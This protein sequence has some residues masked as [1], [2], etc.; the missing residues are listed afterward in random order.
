MRKVFKASRREAF[1]STVESPAPLLLAF[2]VLVLGR[3][4]K[5]A[6][7]FAHVDRRVVVLENF[8]PDDVLDHIFHGN[9]ARHGAKLVDCDGQLL[10]VFKEGL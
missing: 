8:L 6:G 2:A 1:K 5:A 7:Q 3:E 10:M 4:L 9:D